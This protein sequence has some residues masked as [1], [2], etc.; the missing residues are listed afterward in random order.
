MPTGNTFK[1]E[2]SIDRRML[3]RFFGLRPQRGTMSCR[4][5]GESVRPSIHP[6]VHPYVPPQALGRPD[7][8]S[9]RPEPASYMPEP[10][11]RWPELISG[12][13]EPASGRPESAYLRPEPASGMLETASGMDRWTDVQTYRF[14]LCSTGLFPPLGP[15][16]KKGVF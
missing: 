2:I 15:K 7:P 1:E 14:P 4:T 12:R 13:L 9:G 11:C 8:V 3:R 16:P 5:Q 6:C 10:A